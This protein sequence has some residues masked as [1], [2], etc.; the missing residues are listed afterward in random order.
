MLILNLY[1]ALQRLNVVDQH[2]L[3]RFCC[4]LLNRI[5]LWCRKLMLLLVSYRLWLLGQV[6]GR[7]LLILLVR[8]LIDQGK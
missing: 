7:V 4:F 6:A 3:L 8:I 5:R 2:F 1:Q